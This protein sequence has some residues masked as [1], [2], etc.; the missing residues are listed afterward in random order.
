[1]VLVKIAPNYVNSSRGG[2]GM[3]SITWAEIFATLVLASALYV[4]SGCGSSSGGG[5]STGPNL[6]TGSQ[7]DAMLWNYGHWQ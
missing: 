7:W 4:V 5:G 6:A 2:E 1:M 3:K